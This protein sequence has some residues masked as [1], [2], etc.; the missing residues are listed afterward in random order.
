MFYQL[1]FLQPYEDTLKYEDF[2]D[3]VKHQYRWN[4][5]YSF[6]T[7]GFK[8]SL[9]GKMENWNVSMN[10]TDA[11]GI[12]QQIKRVENLQDFR[13]ILSREDYGGFL[14]ILSED[15]LMGRLRGEGAGAFFGDDTVKVIRTFSDVKRV[16][17]KLVKG[18]RGPYILSSQQIIKNSLRVYLNG[19]RI[20]DGYFVGED[21]TTIYITRDFRDGDILTVEYQTVSGNDI[22][23]SGGVV[24]YRNLFLR[25]E[26]V[27]SM[28]KVYRGCIYKSGGDYRF[29]NDTFYLDTKNGNLDCNFIPKENGEYKFLGDRYVFVGS[30]GDHTL[31]PYSGSRD[32]YMGEF[33]Y[34][35]R[36]VGFSLMSKREKDST[37]MGG[38]WDLKLGK[39]VYLISFGEYGYNHYVPV[40]EGG[41]NVKDYNLNG[42]FGLDYE[43]LR[44]YLISSFSS[45]DKGLSGK[46]ELWNEPRFVLSFRMF[47]VFYEYSLGTL[48]KDFSLEGFTLEDS[49]ERNY[50][51]RGG[52]RFVNG[53]V[54]RAS[55]GFLRYEISITTEN[56]KG[57]YGLSKMGRSLIFS[58]NY[59]YFNFNVNSSVRFKKVE[60]F[61]YVGKGWGD[62]ERDSSGNFYPKPFGSYKREIIYQPEDT[63]IYDL[64]LGIFNLLNFNVR[65]DLKGFKG[66]NIHSGYTRDSFGVYG[67]L[68]FDY[69]T[70]TFRYQRTMRGYIYRRF[71][72]EFENF[73]Q[74][75]GYDVHYNSL[76]IGYMFV[77]IEGTKGEGTSLAPFIRLKKPI[78]LKMVYR[79]YLDVVGAEEYLKPKGFSLDADINFL[80]SLEEL[81]LNFVL[82]MHYDHK[83]K[84]V[85]NF[86]FNVFGRI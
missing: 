14:G 22:V 40:R 56:L 73:K 18:F 31:L 23:L 71:F 78:S 39:S 76:Y 8:L 60:R 82:S 2:T 9:N 11:S 28:A 63:V 47:R 52:F 86:G 36:D 54:R 62:Y 33:G 48:Y 21:G 80:K 37:L 51:L 29:S 38:R 61:V 67:S 46:I 6:G 41:F 30:G 43:N 74:N 20:Y 53:E 70:E 25:L 69:E 42:G 65:T 10:L 1:Y 85:W 77:G 83:T 34:S 15:F 4:G 26:S 35:S 16:D 27:R 72:V 66:G 84:L 17:I 50:G 19:L 57:F 24:R 55:D 81:N 75:F 5:Y 13:L 59:G 49:S 12:T 45:Y 58:G 3:T 79:K 32:G 68:Y 7:E 64:A 44:G